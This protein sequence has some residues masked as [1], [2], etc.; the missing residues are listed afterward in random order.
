MEALV[1]RTPTEKV[2]SI[3]KFERCVDKHVQRFI[4][5]KDSDHHGVAI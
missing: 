4:D 5:H 2:E 1:T 3:S